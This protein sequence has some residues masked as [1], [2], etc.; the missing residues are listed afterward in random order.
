MINRF[1]NKKSDDILSN[2]YGGAFRVIGYRS[3]G[4]TTF[5]AALARWPNASSDSPVQSVVANN[6]DGQEL[7]NKARNI[8]EQG[9]QLEAT[10]LDANINEIKD[11]SMTI[12]LTDKFSWTKPRLGEVNRLVNLNINCKDYA[13][14]FFVDLLNP[15]NNPR[16]DNYLADCIMADGIALLIDGYS[17]QMDGDYEIGLKNF[18]TELERSELELKERRIAVILT[19]AEQGEVWANRD[20]SPQIVVSRRFPKVY[21]SLQRWHESKAGKIEFFRASAFGTL[22]TSQAPNATIIRRGI[23][24]TTAVIKKTKIWRPFG[25]ISPLYWLCTGERHPDLDKD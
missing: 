21:D 2:Q 7:I 13:G 12:K 14:E 11:Y 8:L 16:L 17:H 3:S 6:D 20:K 5:M 25:L 9:E 24:G 22:G 19:K 15:V 23:E 1:F 4:K 18:L 10:R